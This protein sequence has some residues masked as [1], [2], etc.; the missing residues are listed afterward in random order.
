M[1]PLVRLSEVISRNS[2]PA[3]ILQVIF[4]FTD[5]HCIVTLNIQV[6]GLLRIYCEFNQD[7][8]IDTNHKRLS[9]PAPVSSETT[10]S[11]L[12]LAYQLMGD[13]LR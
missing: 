4:I 6:L 7:I 5:M 2:D 11:G 9:A 3:V 1:N 10:I 12:N 8:A 13:L